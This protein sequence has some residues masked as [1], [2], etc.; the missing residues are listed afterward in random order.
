MILADGGVRGAF[1]V[2]LSSALGVCEAPPSTAVSIVR[3]ARGD[4]GAL[5]TPTSE[6]SG[7]GGDGAGGVTGKKEGGGG[8]RSSSVAGN[9]EAGI[10][11][12][13]R[14]SSGS[15]LVAALYTPCINR[16]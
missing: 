3:Y 8:D 15:G 12:D 14:W 5:M 16:V 7:R 10:D 11:R 9:N 4:L 1:A 13:S 6:P 2:G